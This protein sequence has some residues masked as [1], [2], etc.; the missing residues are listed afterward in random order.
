VSFVALDSAIGPHLQYGMAVR[1]AG[2]SAVIRTVFSSFTVAEGI[3]IIDTKVRAAF[4]CCQDNIHFYREYRT[5]FEPL[6]GKL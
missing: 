6:V 1:R 4:K 5:E 2:A 3:E